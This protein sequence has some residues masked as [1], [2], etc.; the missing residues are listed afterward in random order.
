MTLASRHPSPRD[1][2]YSLVE[3]LV[4]VTLMGIVLVLGVGS[5]RAWAVAEDQEGTVTDLQTILRQTQTRAITEGVHFCVTFDTAADTYTVNRYACGTPLQRVNGPIKP[6]AGT[7]EFQNVQ[8]RQ[9]DG[10]YSP[11]L[12]F[13][14]TGTATAGSLQIVR[15]GSAKVYTLSVEGFTGRVSIS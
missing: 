4:A 7:I 14:P 2:G 10:T 1:A 11:N 9:P 6:Q 5:F 3:I 13:R 15:A 12:T 8:F